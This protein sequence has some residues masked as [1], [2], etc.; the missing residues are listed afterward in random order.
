MKQDFNQDFHA[1]SNIKL[2]EIR[3][4]NERNIRIRN[5]LEDPNLHEELIEA[6]LDDTEQPELLLEVNDD[7]ITV[8]KYISKEEQQRLREEAQ[9]EEG[10]IVCFNATQMYTCFITLCLVKSSVKS[11]ERRLTE[12]ANNVRGR[13]LEMMMGGRLESNH[14]EELRKEIEVP[15]FMNVKLADEWDEEE[16]KVAKEYERKVIQVS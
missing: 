5:I 4:L 7:E 10:L 3:K 1:L 15:E 8:D 14:E 6:R 2:Q 12:L 11:L 9:R 13:A 16:Q